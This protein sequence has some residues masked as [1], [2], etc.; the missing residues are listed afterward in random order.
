MKAHYNKVSKSHQKRIRNEVAK[1]F[2]KQSNDMTMRVFKMFCVA[3]HKAFGFGKVRISRVLEQVEEIAKER[4]HDE[5]FWAH[6][7]RYCKHL[8][9][10]FDDEDYEKMDK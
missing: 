6:I 9:F 2:E 5:V 3:L 1:E 7:D 4:E 8:G 10:E